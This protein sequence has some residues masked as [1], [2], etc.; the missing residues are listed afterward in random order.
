MVTNNWFN[1]NL[2]S[3]GRYGRTSKRGGK[4]QAQYERVSI[5]GGSLV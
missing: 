1:V 2:S 3:M 4:P 5:W